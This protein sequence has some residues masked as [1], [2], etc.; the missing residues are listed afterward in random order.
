MNHICIIGN[1]TKDTELYE[2]KETD[3]STTYVAVNGYKED[4]TDFFTVKAFGDLAIVFAK[5]VT[6]GKKV[7]VTGVM[8]SRKYE[9]KDG[10]TQTVWEIYAKTVEF[11]SP[12][13]KEDEKPTQRSRKK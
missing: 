9:D 7:A 8:R 2:A 1:A 5:Y 12:A 6:K 13:E 10:K 4:E 3:I 11:L